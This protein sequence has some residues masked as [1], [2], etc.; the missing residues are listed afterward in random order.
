MADHG[1]VALRVVGA[2][3]FHPIVLRCI[4]SMSNYVICEKQ[5]VLSDLTLTTDLRD[6]FL[7][8]EATSW[9]NLYYSGWVLDAVADVFWVIWHLNVM[10][11][12]QAADVAACVLFYYIAFHFRAIRE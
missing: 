11:Q 6:A 1:V 12:G 2:R 4:E 3:A 9:A 7:L 5:L 8:A 10:R